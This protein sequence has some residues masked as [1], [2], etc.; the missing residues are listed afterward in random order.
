[1]DK[2][3]PDQVKLDARLQSRLKIIQSTQELLLCNLAMLAE[4]PAPTFAEKARSEFMVS[5][6]SESG[7]IDPRT[8]RGG[9]AIG[10]LPG[11]ECNRTLMVSTHMDNAFDV[12][13]NTALAITEEQ[14]NGAGV[15]EDNVSL[16]VMLT[17]PDILSRLGIKLKSNLLLV[18]A[19]RF[20]NRGDFEGIRS[21]VHDY[22]GRIDAS[23]NINGLTLG[24]INYFTLSRIRSEI[25]C[26]L[27]EGTRVQH[28]IK[29]SG[30]S[31]IMTLNSIMDQLFGIPLPRKPRTLLNI[32]MISGGERY[33]TVSREAMLRLEALS[34][35]DQIMDELI[36][37][38][39]NICTDVGARHGTK[40]TAE[41]FGRHNAAA[42]SSGHPL[43][44]TALETMQRLD[45]NP[46]VEYTNSQMA[47]TL[48]AGIPSINL[49]LATGSAGKTSN[50][51][52][53]IATLPLGIL[54]LTELLQAIDNSG[55]Y[56]HDQ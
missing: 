17:L 38:I 3:T 15:A 50:S 34:E 21:F 40:V 23:V 1:M 42:L 51:F 11:T 33:S 4:I 49:G 31:A 52:I 37:K 43:V 13:T 26:A 8:D 18:A 48:A 27:I 53:D 35:D 39:K 20:H 19:T 9:N 54:L 41:F 28:M 29:M 12:D 22:P 32:G 30:G 16:A 47:V 24:S 44:K 36:E 6:F 46:K 45:L 14:V 5:R 25:N 7:I 55:E 2:L 10:F 56:R